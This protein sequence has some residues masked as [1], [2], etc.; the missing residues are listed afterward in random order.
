VDLR[1]V[2]QDGAL[3]LQAGILWQAELHR[4]PKAAPI[5]AYAMPVLPDVESRIT[6]SGVSCPVSK[7]V[8]IIHRPARSL[9]EPPGLNHSALA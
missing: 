7:A 6:L 2:R 5:I 8:M 9:T 4:R 3:A 1:P